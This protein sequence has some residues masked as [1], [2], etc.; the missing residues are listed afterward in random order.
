MICN[1]SQLVV[2]HDPTIPRTSTNFDCSDMLFSQQQLNNNL[3]D[4]I[5]RHEILDSDARRRKR[6][7]AVLEAHSY[8]GFEKIAGR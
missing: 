8:E 6:L 5:Y 4:T 1:D 7:N 2:R 3:E